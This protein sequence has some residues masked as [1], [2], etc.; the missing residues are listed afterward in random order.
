MVLPGDART[1]LEQIVPRLEGLFRENETL[2]ELRRMF[3]IFMQQED[4]S[5]AH[6]TVAFQKS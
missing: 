3:F 6:F 2:T 1:S 4:E 5:L